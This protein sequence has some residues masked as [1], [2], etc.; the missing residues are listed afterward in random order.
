MD[1]RLLT[2]LLMTAAAALLLA[3]GIVLARRLQVPPENAQLIALLAEADSLR[4]EAERCTAELADREARFR[5]FDQR[6]DSL[7]VAVRAQEEPGPRARVAAENYEEYL[8][9]FDR[10]NEA[11]P[12]WHAQ[13]DSLRAGWNACRLAAETHNTVL[14]SA[15]ALRYGTTPPEQRRRPRHKRCAAASAGLTAPGRTRRAHP[16]D[17]CR[18]APAPPA[19]ALASAP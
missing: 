10:Y 16:A 11:V 12:V 7:R 9:L 5:V 3:V 13:A 17:P 14:E 19:P 6:V 8:E 15:A 2:K 1:R 18:A 4:D